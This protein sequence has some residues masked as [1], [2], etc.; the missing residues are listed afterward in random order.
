MRW[1]A[2]PAWRATGWKASPV[3]KAG[4]SSSTRMCSP[5]RC[6]ASKTA[7]PATPTSR[8]CRIPTSWR[9]SIVLRAT[10]R[11]ARTTR[12]ASTV[13]AGRWALRRPRAARI[14]MGNTTIL[15]VKDPASSVFKLNLPQTCAQ[16]PQ[17]SRPD[18]REYRMKYP[19]APAQYA[20][21]IHGRAL[22]KMGLI[23]A[24]S[25]NDCHGVHNIRRSVDRS[26]PINHTNIAKTCG[27]CHV[28][29]EKIYNAEH[30][31]P[32]SRQRVIR[33]GR[34]AVIAIRR[35]R[36]SHR[37]AGISRNW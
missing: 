26:S 19:E 31:R 34:F 5:S 35:T 28:G 7:L 14:A 13:S 33:A 8:R 36:S 10:M 4:R 27:K 20:E 25:C 17:Q 15:P 9:R 6:T 18:A 24:P 23:V 3:P 16:V 2:K 22:L 21:S 1:P 32:T 29:V 11:L 12:P 30:P 37:R